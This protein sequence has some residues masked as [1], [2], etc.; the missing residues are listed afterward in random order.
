MRRAVSGQQIFTS[1]YIALQSAARV[2]G[3][4]SAE[5]GSD[6]SSEIN[7]KSLYLSADYPATKSAH[8]SFIQPEKLM[9]S[10]TRKIRGRQKLKEW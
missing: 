1:T 5:H 3:S 7:E 2:T 6:K 4:T 9:W 8:A 10:A